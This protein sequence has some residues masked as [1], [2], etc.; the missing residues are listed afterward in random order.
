MTD[1]DYLKD[2]FN[3]FK[4]FIINESELRKKLFYRINSIFLERLLV[5]LQY[6]ADKQ[7]GYSKRKTKTKTKQKR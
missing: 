3:N 5:Q 7:M 2:D 6:Q 4:H 1:K